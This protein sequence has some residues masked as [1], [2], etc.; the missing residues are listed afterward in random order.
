M[1]QIPIGPNPTT[2]IGCHENQGWR[3]LLLNIDKGAKE[4][5]IS[6]WSGTKMTERPDLRAVVVLTKD[7]TDDLIRE[8]L[9]LRAELADQSD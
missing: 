3:F 5:S 7:E 1:S 6:P 4:I 8:L 9:R 2:T